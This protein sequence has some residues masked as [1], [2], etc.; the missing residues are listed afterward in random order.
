MDDEDDGAKPATDIDP[1]KPEN[2]YKEIIQT[3]PL[4]PIIDTIL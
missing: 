4:N 2:K 1:E 3:A